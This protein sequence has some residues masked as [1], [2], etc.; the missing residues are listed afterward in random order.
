MQLNNIDLRVLIKG[1]PIKEYLHNGDFFVEGREGSPFELQVTNR[2]GFNVEVILSVD[3][4]SILDGE[5]AGPESNGYFIGRG[6]T[7]VIPGWKLNQ[8]AVAAFVFSGKNK[9]YAAQTTNST[10]N[11]GIIGAMV[12]AEGYNRVT[13]PPSR[14]QPLPSRWVSPPVAHDPYG[15]WNNGRAT[16]SGGPPP[17]SIMKGIVRGAGVNQMFGS[18]GS[19]STMACSATTSAVDASA[20][21]SYATAT[22]NTMWHSGNDGAGSGLDA[23]MLDGQAG[24]YF[25]AAAQNNLGTGF[26]EETDFQT[27]EV[28]FVRGDM[29]AMLVA[30]YDNAQGLRARGIDLGGRRKPT[31][32][33]FPAMITKGCKPPRGWQG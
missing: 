25:A 3:G 12:F 23:D 16:L 11:N 10:N 5:A 28:A 8:E 6:D 20:S 4:L 9:S 26:G 17:G 29:I 21:A 32:Q 24:T 22:A 13:P 14:R 15:G 27:R 30:Y 2:N 1:R 33:A 7:V 18:A 19:A 31:P